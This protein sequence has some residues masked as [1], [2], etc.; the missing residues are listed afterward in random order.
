MACYCF[1]SIIISIQ[2]TL[3]D[4]NGFFLLDISLIKV[5]YLNILRFFQYNFLKCNKS[6]SLHTNKQW[7][8]SPKS[9]WPH[10]RLQTSLFLSS[11]RYLPVSIGS[12][13]LHGLYLHNYL[14]ETFGK[15]VNYASNVI[16]GSV[17]AAW[18]L[19]NMLVKNSAVRCYESVSATRWVTLD[20][21]GCTPP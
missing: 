13:W 12:L 14:A 21:L 17:H 2:N 7:Y 19:F 3:T 18:P 16:T 20:C 10:I 5:I 1:T 6:L 8:S 11:F 15:S 4:L 9:P